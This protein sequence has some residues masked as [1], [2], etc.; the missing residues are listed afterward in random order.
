MNRLT[1]AVGCLLL[2]AAASAAGAP[3]A[4][5]IQA[6]IQASGPQKTIADLDAKNQLETVLGRI[7]EGG[8]EWIAL[9]PKLAPGA[10]GAAAE[11]LGIVLAQA[12][13][14][15]AAGVL[16]VLTDGPGDISVERVCSTPFI[17][18]SKASDQAYDQRAIQALRGVTDPVLAKK[19]DACLTR[20]KP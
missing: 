9:A 7:G 16:R 11:G 13:P 14:I 18:T 19:R 17:E 3:D 10:D 12:L 15:N 6:S 1:I 4:F 20:L 5:S 2:P 8:N